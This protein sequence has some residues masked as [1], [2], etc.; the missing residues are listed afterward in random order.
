MPNP[1]SSY[2]NTAGPDQLISS[3]IN[4]VDGGGLD[5]RREGAS[6]QV[7][8]EL[9]LDMSD[10]ELLMLKVLWEQ[11]TTDYDQTFHIKSRQDTNKAYYLGRQGDITTFGSSIG[12]PDNLLFE[13][14]ET[15]LPA[16]LSK[17]PEPVV[18]SSNDETGVD[19]SND[20]KT[21]LQYHADYLNLRL[22]LKKM[23]R[24]WLIYFV[25]CVKHKWNKKTNDIDLEVVFP[26]NLKMDKDGWIDDRGEYHGKFLGELHTENAS[27]LIEMFPKKAMYIIDSVQGKLGTSCTY[28]EWSTDEYCFYSYKD[29]ILGKYRNPNWNYDFKQ[30]PEDQEEYMDEDEE[31]V[32]KI[33]PGKNHFPYPKRPYTFFS[34]FNLGEHPYDETSLIEQNIP[35]QNLIT[36]RNYQ[37]K[38]NL[39]NANNGLAVSGDHFN[40]EDAKE[41]NDMVRKGKG[42]F[43]PSGDVRTAVMRLEA[44]TL[45]DGLFNE[46]QD[47]RNELRSIF[48]TQGISSTAPSG[49]ETVRGKILNQQYDS[50]RIGGGISDQLAQV[51]DNIFNWWVQMYYV[52]YDQ[53]HVEAVLG[54][55]KAKQYVELERASLIQMQAKLTVSVAADSMKPKDELSQ[56]NMATD[57]YSNGSLDPLSYYEMLNLPDPE[58]LLYRLIMWKTNPMA[59]LQGNGQMPPGGGMPQPQQ[60]PEQGVQPPQGPGELSA[61]PASDSLAQVPIDGQQGAM[62]S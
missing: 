49:D 47:K 38:A 12:I 23:V 4:K 18:Y 14:V 52:Y 13:A 54:P 2:L 41:A 30:S 5:E 61:Q 48:G 9:E 37:I 36:D 1:L 57:M 55:Q 21:M 40:K 46:L 17:N 39:Q 58:K 3:Q 8:D 16:A 34:V 50:T 26:Q 62:P 32:N 22:K 6:D 59:L 31:Q 15:F 33:V 42:I 51:A 24:H 27:E 53:P 11:N 60:G 28:T 10:E 20:V 19:L 7:F 35:N 25:G 45:P 44:P 43:V 56:M 29:E